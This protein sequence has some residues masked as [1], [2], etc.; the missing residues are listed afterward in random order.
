PTPTAIILSRIAQGAG[1][2]IIHPLAQAILLDLYPKR[3]HGRMLGIWGAVIMVGPIFGPMLGGIITDLASWRWVF[4]VN[5]P[6]GA[7]AIWGMRRVLPKTEPNAN[8]AIDILGIAL[9]AIAVG[10]LQLWLIRGLGQDWLHSP[11]LL[12]ETAVAAVA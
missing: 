9:L 12:A 7:L 4:A 8:M 2:G 5:L 11:E 1:G 6:L 3:Q 10:A